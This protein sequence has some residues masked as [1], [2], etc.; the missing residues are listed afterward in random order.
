MGD[1]ALFW[2]FFFLERENAECNSS[3]FLCNA[4]GSLKELV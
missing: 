3:T 4:H 1:L 2:V